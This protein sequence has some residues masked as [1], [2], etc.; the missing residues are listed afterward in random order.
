MK[1]YF[2]IFK[3]KWMK[4]GTVSFLY[5]LFV[6]WLR[7]PLWFAGLAVIYDIYI[8]KKVKWI[9]WKDK[10][11]EAK[12]LRGWIDAIIFAVIAVTFIRMF[13]VEAYTIPTGSMEKSLLIGDYLFVDKVTYGPRIPNTPL[14]FPL[15]HNILPFTQITKSYLEWIKFDYK[16]LAGLRNIKRDDIVVFNFPHGDTVLIGNPSRDF[17]EWRRKEGKNYK[18]KKSDYTV[19]PVDKKDHYVKRCIAIPGDTVK[20]TDGDVYVNGEKQKEIPKKQY[21]YRIQTDGKPISKKTWDEMDISIS[22]RRKADVYGFPLTGENFEKI[23]K[24]PNTVNIERIKNYPDP[25]ANELFP[26]DKKYNWDIDNYG[27][28]WIPKKGTTIELTLDN[29]PFY[30][31]IIDIYENNDLKIKDDEI[32]INGE[33][34]NTYT[35]KMD[36]YW[37]MGDNRHNSLDS[38]YWGYV[39]EDHIVGRPMFVWFSSDPEKSFPKNIRWNR[40]FRRIK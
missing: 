8:S 19:R 33:K 20:I 13:F 5:I 29:L 16:R 18:L 11:G 2:N 22:D 32:F 28:V 30:K 24:L 35:F 31:R 3:N 34:T 17:Y 14:S 26:F 37:M 39:P 4:F 9:F 6:I 1:K 38:R 7:S 10:N 27:P 15:V 25:S 36:Y 23:K 12:G 21:N 40:L